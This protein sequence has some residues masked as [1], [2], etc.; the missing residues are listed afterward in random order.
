MARFFLQGQD[1]G[2]RGVRAHVGIADDEALFVAFDARDH[3]RLVLH[4]LRAVDERNAALLGERDGHGVVGHRLHDGRYPGDVHGKRAILLPLAVF[5]QR[6][7]QADG[8]GDAL[9]RRIAG[10]QQI[11]AKRAG[12]FREVSG[13]SDLLFFLIVYPL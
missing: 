11:F 12:G 7:L 4:G 1:I 13:H 3:R 6:G 8:G 5:H 9:G 2:Q 10:H